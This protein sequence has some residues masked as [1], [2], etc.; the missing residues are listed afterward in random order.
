MKGTAYLLQAAIVIAWWAGLFI[1]DRFFAA[2]QF[3]GIS[4][5]AFWAFFLPDM[6]LMLT[7]LAYNLFL[8]FADRTFHT[9]TTTRTSAL[10]LKTLVQVIC[11]WGLL[12]AVVPA[13]IL[14]AFHSLHIPEFS[15]RV[16]CS[17]TA[18]ALFSALGLASA[19]FMVW[20]G[21][22]T[23]L[24]ADHAPRLVTRGPYASVRNPMAVSG[25]GQ[26][27]C[28]AAA[29]QSIPLLVYSVLG[30]VARE[31]VIKPIEERDLR[32]RFGQEYEDYRRRVY[33]WIPCAVF[34]RQPKSD[35]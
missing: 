24:P 32:D 12:L 21:R 28:L 27:L 17:F 20:H 4:P 8:C 13:V 19:G 35:V 5:Q 1:S 30:A 6:L 18:F 7:G 16:V 10:A 34:R 29:F 22:G 15:V 9:T 23:P 31:F 14:Q 25:I 3:S 26:G 2:F 11:F 33:C